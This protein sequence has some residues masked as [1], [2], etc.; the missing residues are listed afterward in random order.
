LFDLAGGNSPYLVGGCVMVVVLVL[1]FRLPRGLPA[2]AAA[3]GET[4]AS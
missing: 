3:T 1:A 2:R 4:P